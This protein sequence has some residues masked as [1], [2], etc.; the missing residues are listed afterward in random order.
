MIR[1]TTEKIV[2]IK[3]R[4]LTARSHQK[5]YADR[6]SKPLEFKVGDMVLLKVSPWKGAVHFGKRRKLSPRYIRPFKILARVGPVAYT[7]ELPEELKGIH[8]TFHVSN[9][10]KCL[11]N[12]NLIILL[13]EIQLDNK[14]QF[15]EE[16]VS[17]MKARLQMDGLRRSGRN[18]DKEVYDSDHA[19]TVASGNKGKSLSSP[20]ALCILQL[21]PNQKACLE[22]IRFGGMVDFNVDRILSKLGLYM[23]DNFNDNKMEIKLS[24]CSIVLTKDMIGEI[25]GLKNEGFDVLEGNPNRDDQ[26]VRSWTQQYGD[27]KEIKPADVK[28][29]IRKS[30]EADINFKLNFIVLF[31]SIMGN[32]RQKGVAAIVGKP[33]S[34][35]TLVVL[36]TEAS[37]SKQHGKS[38]SDSY[39]LSD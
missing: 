29:R 14:L 12:E 35:A 9:L 24:K 16:P 39:Y 3:N 32:I 37:Q 18:K 38:E 36:I 22:E 30:G 2:Q 19:K 4:L 21:K 31:T 10:K 17:R 5:I 34:I 28:T 33:A 8:S 20:R 27:D 11:A 26:M 23:V 25:L 15:I 6:T 1:E 7:L 13:N